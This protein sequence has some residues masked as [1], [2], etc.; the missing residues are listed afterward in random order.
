MISSE[1][2]CM[3]CMHEIGD[4]KKCPY[5]GYH[6]E[7]PQPAPYLGSLAKETGEG[8]DP[9]HEEQMAELNRLRAPSAPYVAPDGDGLNLSWSGEDIVRGFITG[10]I[11]RRRDP[12]AGFPSARSGGRL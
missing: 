10:E 1:N 5:C 4:E 8:D 9:C 7:T 11:L 2:L 3:G 6:V 12:R